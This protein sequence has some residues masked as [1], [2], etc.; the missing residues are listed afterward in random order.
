[1]KKI[2]F[3]AAVIIFFMLSA[4]DVSACT[5]LMDTK[6]PVN[7]QVKTAYQ[8]AAV[9]FY[10]EVTEI[11]RESKAFIVKIRVERSWKG[12]VESETIVGTLA[13]SAMCG[14]T[15]EKG[16]KYMVY[17]YGEGG[18]LGVILCSRTYPSDQDARYLNK[19]KKPVIF[20]TAIRKNQ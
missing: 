18:K 3:L 19:I 4:G 15:F 12:Q 6:T 17:A 1:M 10:G 20:T 16:K 8:K 13:D 9:V 14:Y 2:T 11:T 5:C 7:K